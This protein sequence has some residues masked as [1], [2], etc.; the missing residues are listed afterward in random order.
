M[1]RALLV[2]AV[3]ARSYSLNSQKPDSF[4][5]LEQYPHPFP[6]TLLVLM[7]LQYLNYELLE[8]LMVLPYIH[9][10]ISSK[11]IF[12]SELEDA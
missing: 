1:A 8:K 5:S 11:V 10:Y 4:L 12:C 3:S 9:K 2:A 6:P 7:R